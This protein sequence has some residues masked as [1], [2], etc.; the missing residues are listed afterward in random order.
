MTSSPSTRT[1]S[2]SRATCAS[3]SV[4]NTNA[5]SGADRGYLDSVEVA[6]DAEILVVNHALLAYDLATGG[7][8]VLGQMTRSSSTRRTRR[9]RRSAAPTRCAGTLDRCAALSLA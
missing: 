6:R 1:S 3:L 5:P 4:S 7:G 9:L 8:K 2:P